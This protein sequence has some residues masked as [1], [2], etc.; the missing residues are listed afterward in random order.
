MVH[1][2]IS[3]LEQRLGPV[4]VPLGFVSNPPIGK[5]R[6]DWVNERTKTIVE[7]Y[8]DYWHMSPVRY[9]PESLNETTGRTADQQWQIDAERIET[10]TKMGY[11]IV[12]FWETELRRRK[13]RQK[14]TWFILSRL[15]S[16]R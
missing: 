4:L 10:L 11:T 9:R 1:R 16:Q 6:P 13:S 14:L 5:Y 2:P 8:G 3:K 15:P 7:V 12:I